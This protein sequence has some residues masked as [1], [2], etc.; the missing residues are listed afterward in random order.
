MEIHTLTT[1][2]DEYIIIEPE[3]DYIIFECESLRIEQVL[4]VYIR[5]FRFTA[6]MYYIYSLL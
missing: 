3:V 4:C 5:Y 1:Q 2:G 6:H